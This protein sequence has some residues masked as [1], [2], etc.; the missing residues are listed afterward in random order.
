[1]RAL[2][3]LVVLVVVAAIAVVVVRRRRPLPA[4]DAPV[5]PPLDVLVRSAASVEEVVSMESTEPIAFEPVEVEADV[6]E[7]EAVDADADAFEPDDTDVVEVGQ[8]SLPRTWVTPVDGA[9]PD[10]HPIKANASSGIYHVPGGRSYAR[11][12]PE[13][14]YAT[15]EDAEADGFRRAKL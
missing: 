12:R 10:G 9:C 6:V 8:V 13:R 3:R 4:A 11:T 5:W 7:V 15:P 14:C 1:M 2:R